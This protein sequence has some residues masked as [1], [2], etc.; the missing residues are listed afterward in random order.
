LSEYRENLPQL[1]GELFMADAGLETDLIFNHGIDIREFAAHTLLPDVRGREAMAVYFRTFMAL[2]ESHAAGFVM[3]S[4]TWKAHTHWADDLAATEQELHEANLDSIA[5]ISELRD[6]YSNN[7]NPIVL[8]GIIGPRG[9]AYASKAWQTDVD[10]ETYHARQ[11]G[12]LADTNV[13]MLTATTF[14]HS[15]EAIGVVRAAQAV[16]LPVVISF[17]VETNG[18]LPAGESIQDAIRAVDDATQGAAAYFVVN[19]AHPD[20]FFHML[21]DSESCRRIRGLRCNAS[22]L[23]HAELDACEV[24][25]DGH[26]A[27]LASHYSGITQKMPW[28][29]IFGGCCGTDLRHVD[30]IMKAVKS[31]T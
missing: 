20:H 26:P 5:F 4:Q 30:H 9:N 8:N 6:E 3:D 29:N 18:A 17:T 31:R 23:S 12:W 19:C 14:P 22:K 10:A 28:V 16:G 2:A 21:D 24:L 25:D 15:A 13:D 1:S 7:S 11:V 27:E